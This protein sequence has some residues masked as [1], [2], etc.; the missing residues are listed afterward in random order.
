MMRLKITGILLMCFLLVGCTSTVIHYDYGEG[1]EIVLTMWSIAT[2]SD[3]FHSSYLRAIEDF[4]EANPGVRIHLETF[5]NESYKTKITLAVAA[6]ELPDIFY[7]WG[8]GFSRPFVTSG[9]VLDL[10]SFYAE[11]EEDLPRRMLRNVTFGDKI[12]GSVINAPISMLFYNEA[13]FRQYHVPVPTNWDE[14]IIACQIFIENDI[15]PISISAQD[16][17]VIAMLHDALTLRAAGPTIVQSVLSK[18]GIYSYDSEFFLP[19]ARM[20]R[21]LVEINAFPRY[22]TLLSNDEALIYFLHGYAAMMVSGNWTASSIW[23]DAE[24]PYDFAVTPVPAVWPG[25]VINDF[26]GGAADV[27]MVSA[28]T[29]HPEIAGR[30]VFEISR[31]ISQYA[32]LDGAATP[33]WRVVYDDARVNPLARRIAEYATNARSMTLWFDRFLEARDAEAYLNYLHKLFVGDV[34]PEEFVSL[35]AEQLVP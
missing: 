19:S 6:N 25:S 7:S 1:D 34:T 3:A 12:F 14:W 33:T 4:E 11:F 13:L 27:L 20:L 21:E 23:T 15:T 10:T 24:N 5:D 35:M 16:T 31:S 22:A 28:S 32:Y 2:A 9:K 18:Q 17:W 26:M 29:R 8:G 30:A